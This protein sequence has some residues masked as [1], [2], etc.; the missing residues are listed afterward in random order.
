MTSRYS[1]AISPFAL[2]RVYLQFPQCIFMGFL[3]QFNEITSARRERR[4]EVAPGAPRGKRADAKVPTARR[5]QPLNLKPRNLSTSHP[6]T[7]QPLNLSPRNLATSQPLTL[8]PR[9]LST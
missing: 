7:S 6:E 5:T 4:A 1:I 2:S 8:I 9:N 3:G